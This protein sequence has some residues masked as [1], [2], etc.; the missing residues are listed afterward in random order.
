[1]TDYLKLCGI[2]FGLFRLMLAI[3]TVD[4]TED[5]EA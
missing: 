1:V 4:E 2:H 5:G 3:L